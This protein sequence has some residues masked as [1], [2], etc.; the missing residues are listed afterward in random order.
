M[1]RALG[2]HLA[3]IAALGISSVVYPTAAQSVQF[4]Q[5][6]I[7]DPSRFVIMAA[8]IGNTGSY[9]LLIFEQLNNR[10]LCWREMGNNP[11]IVEPL[12]LEFDF[13]GICGRSTDSN[14]YSVRVAGEDLGKRYNLRLARQQN[15][16]VLIG[17]SLTDREV[18]FF[19]IG[20]TNGLTDGFLKINLDP[21]WR[22]T[23]RSHQ[24]KAVG[25]L[26]F[27]SD[28][29][30]LELAKN[31]SPLLPI[32]PPP[33]SP[34]P[35]QSPSGSDS[36]PSAPPPLENQ[37]VP[38][39]ATPTNPLPPAVQPVPP[40][41]GE[42]VA[43][44]APAP[45]APGTPAPTEI[46]P[47][48]SPTPAPT[49]APGNYVVP[50]TPSNSVPS[51]SAPS[52]AP[53]SLVSR[54]NT[55]ARSTVAI[56]VTPPGRG[57][58]AFPNNPA[59]TGYRVVVYA[60]T[61]EQQS[62]VRQLVPSAFW[63]NVNGQ[64]AMQVGVFRDRAI[65]NSLQQQLA[66]QNLNVQI[67]PTIINLTTLPTGSAPVTNPPTPR[68]VANTDTFNLPQPNNA[69]LAQL[70]SL[71]ATYYYTH[72]AQAAASG[73]PLLDLTG[74]NLGVTL[75]QRDWCA[76]ALEGSVQVANGQQILGTFNFAGR[77]DTAQVDCF[78]FYPRLKSLPAT[79]R[80]RFKLSNTPYGEGVG[81][82]QL[83]PYRTIAV[84][85]TMIPIG[86]VVYIPEARGTVVTLPS[87]QQAVHDGYFYAADVGAAVKE[88]HI[89][90]YL[91]VAERSP[92]RFVQ[93]TPSATFTAYLIKDPQ[94]QIT[95]ASQHRFAGVAQR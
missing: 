37:P 39:G 92:F 74:N 54:Q 72:Q 15:E 62:Q 56:P 4:D 10:R 85:K 40:A 12:F 90:V 42:F 36:I 51:N 16:L 38:S 94:I 76:A 83:V 93:S 87:G 88:N 47:T 71:W 55:L 44:I 75:S 13:T 77:G 79:N 8:P 7:S 59:G 49:N 35:T 20:R 28:R 46:Q 64:T 43:P 19:E 95:L 18:E 29:S 69:T 33:V 91:G 25:H 81:G 84:D 31:A 65:A 5:M 78:P 23:R 45:I 26:Y 80:V 2:S 14:A 89:D 11:T 73:Y 66:A 24:G 52:A 70:P 53:K 17:F 68:F 27:T 60:A 9:K 21:N 61:A 50:T 3:L 30:L 67:L 63:T 86:S 82:N 6:E 22:L 32:S 57:M 34:Q 1:K 41:S 48:P 58:S